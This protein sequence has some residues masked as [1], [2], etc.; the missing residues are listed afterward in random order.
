MHTSAA[1]ELFFQKPDAHADTRLVVDDVHVYVAP[2]AAF[3]TEV[4]AANDRAIHTTNTAHMH[5]L[6]QKYHQLAAASSSASSGDS[7]ARTIQEQ[8]SQ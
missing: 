7:C 8:L 4:H 6:I 3:E 5:V 2:D 1:A